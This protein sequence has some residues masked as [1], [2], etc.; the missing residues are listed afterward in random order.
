M[1]GVFKGRAPRRREDESG[2][3]KYTK[4]FDQLLPG[5]REVL[6]HESDHT[7]QPCWSFVTGSN[8][9]LGR[10]EH[11]SEKGTL[12][13]ARCVLFCLDCYHKVDLKCLGLRFGYYF[14]F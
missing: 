9:P 1:Q 5:P 6:Q 2:V 4:L 11:E 8:F 7:T 12:A 10:K 13:D 14:R 3:E